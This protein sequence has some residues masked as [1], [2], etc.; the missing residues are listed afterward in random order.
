M[1][2][3][4]VADVLY[5]FSGATIVPWPPPIPAGHQALFDAAR[6]TRFPWLRIR[7]G[8]AVAGDEDGWRAWLE[9]FV[10]PADLIAAHRALARGEGI[11]TRTTAGDVPVSPPSSWREELP[12]TFTSSPA[13][14]CSRC[15]GRE[16][17]RMPD[18]DVCVA[19]PPLVPCRPARTG[20]RRHE[21]SPRPDRLARPDRRSTRHR[22][23]A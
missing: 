19:C 22:R 13:Q 11:V 4:T 23:D 2:G 6:A 21:I 10:S 14:T 8:V 1:I 12:A 7:D 18:G 3:V 17:Q 15:G 5:V 16:W 9:G 20:G